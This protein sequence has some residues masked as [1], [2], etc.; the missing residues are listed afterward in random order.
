MVRTINGYAQRMFRRNGDRRLEERR[1][2]SEDSGA[3]EIV[4]DIWNKVA[5]RRHNWSERRIDS[6]ESLNHR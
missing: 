4:C 2:Q 5:C 6:V 1:A 3:W